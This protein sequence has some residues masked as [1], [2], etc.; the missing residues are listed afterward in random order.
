MKPAFQFD[1]SARPITYTRPR[2]HTMLHECRAC[3]EAE[4]SK[5]NT[6]LG[7]PHTFSFP[8]LPTH[9]CRAVNLHMMTL[10]ILFHMDVK[11]GSRRSGFGPISHPRDTTFTRDLAPQTFRLGLE[12]L[13]FWRKK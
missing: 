9:E 5:T 6:S 7:I 4:K 1:F 8:L 11:W 10:K 2:Q 3:P 13:I 12:Q